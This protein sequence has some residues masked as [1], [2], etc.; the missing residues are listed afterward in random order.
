MTKK[1]FFL[2]A[3][4]ASFVFLA[5]VGLTSCSRDDDSIPT[6]EEY[7]LLLPKS[8]YAVCRHCG[9]NINEGET[10][11]HYFLPTE[12][13]ADSVYCVWHGYY[14]RH[15]VQYPTNSHK[16]IHIGGYFRP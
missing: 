14:H 5:S 1:R 2:F 8:P 7:A 4:V 6:I 16:W 10:H 12:S 9:G 3:I 15:I 11:V 13:C